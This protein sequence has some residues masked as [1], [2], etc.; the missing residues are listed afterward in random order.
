MAGAAVVEALSYDLRYALRGLRATPRFTLVALLLLALGIGGVATLYSAIR[1][2][3]LSPPGGVTEPRGLIWL[4]THSPWRARPG[5]LSYP[6]FL[7]YRAG[8]RAVLAGLAAYDVAPFSL[9]SG[10][11][12]SRIRG[13]VV[14]GDYFGVLGVRT[15]VGRAFDEAELRPGAGASV[16]VLGHDLWRARLG[17]DAASSDARSSSTA[18]R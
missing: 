14:V 1:G 4:T 17:G 12:P 2:A 5:G 8:G 7:D 10:G 16:V 15:V 13:H 6:D 9:G 3:L 11:A 18:L